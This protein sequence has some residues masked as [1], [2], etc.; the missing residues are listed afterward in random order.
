VVLSPSAVV[1]VFGRPMALWN[2]SSAGEK[3]FS[4]FRCILTGAILTVIFWGP[5]HHLFFE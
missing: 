2:V 1:D 5:A 4:D 3:A